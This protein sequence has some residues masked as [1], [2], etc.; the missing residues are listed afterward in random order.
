MHLVTGTVMRATGMASGQ[1]GCQDIR[2]SIR[3]QK[4]FFEQ[5]GLD[6]S[7][8]YNGTINLDISPLRYQ[9]GT[10]DL[11]VHGVRWHQDWPP[12]SF[13][14]FEGVFIFQ[15]RRHRAYVYYPHPE[16]KPTEFLGNHMLEIMTEYIDGIT[17]GATA[18][19]SIEAQKLTFT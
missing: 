5:A 6:L 18:S 15:Q 4:P 10:S 16:T 19:F 12:E 8:T 14:L 17:Y 13:S 1:R 2:G 9:P 11:T 3:A 7:W